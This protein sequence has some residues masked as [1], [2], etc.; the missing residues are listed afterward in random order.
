MNDEKDE[1]ISPT[2]PTLHRK[3]FSCPI[4]EIT[5]LGDQQ[6]PS[7]P[8]KQANDLLT[9]NLDVDLREDNGY[10]AFLGELVNHQMIGRFVCV[11]AGKFTIK[12][13]R[14]VCQTLLFLLEMHHADTRSWGMALI[15]LLR[16]E[17]RIENRS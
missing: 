15:G 12:G 1:G 13:G 6:I 9:V 11:H 14:D 3:V 10:L 16:L 4:C 5:F 8:S 17:M 7:D 2:A